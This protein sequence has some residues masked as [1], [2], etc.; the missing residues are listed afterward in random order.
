MP[1]S[2]LWLNLVVVVLVI[3]SSRSSHQW[4][5]QYPRQKQQKVRVKAPLYQFSFDCINCR[6]CCAVRRACAQLPAT[7]LN[8][9]IHCTIICWLKSHL[10]LSRVFICLFLL[11]LCRCR[12]RFGC[13][14]RQVYVRKDYPNAKSYSCWWWD[15][16]AEQYATLWNWRV[17]IASKWV[18]VWH[19]Q[20]V[21]SWVLLGLFDCNIS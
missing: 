4:W 13:F 11:Q 5:Q 1:L 8:S 3:N 12:Q 2:T 19:A 14:T 7:K 15:E 18:I 16:S 17:Y 6:A 21:A 20:P 10:F 9:F